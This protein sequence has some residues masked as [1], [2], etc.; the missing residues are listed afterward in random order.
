M[1]RSINKWIGVGNVGAFPEIRSTPSGDKVAKVSMATGV[2]YTDRSGQKQERTEWHKL[3]FWGKLADVVERYVHKGD[4]LYVEAEVR[5]ST[6][7]EGDATRYWTDMHVREMVML[8][9]TGERETA[10]ASDPLADDAP[11]SLPF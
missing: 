5:Y 2:N 9:G 8:G 10:P 7:G 4:R 11:D 6:T 3:T 1:S